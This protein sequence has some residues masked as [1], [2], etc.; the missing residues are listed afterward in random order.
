MIRIAIPSQVIEGKCGKNKEGIQNIVTVAQG[1]SL[2]LGENIALYMNIS[3][4]FLD[5]MS[6]LPHIISTFL[7]QFYHT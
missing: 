7:N 4:P 1:N 5:T 2:F 6:R 3:S